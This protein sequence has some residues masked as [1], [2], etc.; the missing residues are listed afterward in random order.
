MILK[1][2]AMLV[3]EL[4]QMLRDPKMR[5]V[6]LGIPTI[7]MLVMSFALTLDVKNINITVLD[8]DRSKVTEE[9]IHN[10][11]A[12]RIFY[13]AKSIRRTYQKCVICWMQVKSGELLFFRPE[14]SKNFMKVYRLMYR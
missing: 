6:I 2:R 8:Y 11:T 5:M 14:P 1:L 13:C 9:I 3:K 12:S 7:Q 10:L 4:K